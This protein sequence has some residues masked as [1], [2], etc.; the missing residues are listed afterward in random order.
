MTNKNLNDDVKDKNQQNTAK[1]YIA[2]KKN[3]ADVETNKSNILTDRNSSKIQTVK[4]T[5]VSCRNSIKSQAVKSMVIVREETAIKKNAPEK[6]SQKNHVAKENI[7]DKSETE[8]VGTEITFNRCENAD[9]VKE[10][11]F[12]KFETQ[13][14]YNEFQKEAIKMFKNKADQV[15]IEDFKRLKAKYTHEELNETEIEKFKIIKEKNVEI[16]RL[17]AEYINKVKNQLKTSE[18]SGKI[19]RKLVEVKNSM[20]LCKSNVENGKNSVE[21]QVVKNTIVAEK[22]LPQEKAVKKT[23]SEENSW[24]EWVEKEEKIAC[25]IL[26]IDTS[27]IQYRCYLQN[28]KYED[29]TEKEKADY[30]EY[31]RMKAKYSRPA[32][33]KQEQQIGRM[34]QQD[35]EIKQLKYEHSRK[36]R[37]IVETLKDEEKLKEHLMDESFDEDERELVYKECMRLSKI[38]EEELRNTS[39]VLEA[40]C[41]DTSSDEEGEEG[42]QQSGA[43]SKI[44]CERKNKSL[45]KE[46]D[47]RSDGG[48]SKNKCSNKD[49]S[50]EAESNLVRTIRDGSYFE[51]KRNI[52]E[53]RN[54]NYKAA[55]K[56]VDDQMAQMSGSLREFE[57]HS[58]EDPNMRI[59]FKDDFS[60][61]TKT[62]SRL[63]MTPINEAFSGK[64]NFDTGCFSCMKKLTDDHFS[65]VNSKI[66][67]LQKKIKCYNVVKGMKLDKQKADLLKS[68]L[69]EYLHGTQDKGRDVAG[70]SSGL[71]GNVYTDLLKSV[72]K[73]YCEGVKKS[74]QG[75]RRSVVAESDLNDKET[76]QVSSETKDDLVVRLSGQIDDILSCQLAQQS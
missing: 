62:F 56:Y 60:D 75:K 30:D 12:D 5:V 17:R 74:D 49:N 47:V 45:N 63:S 9:V 22:N 42:S 66:D 27:S 52:R 70:R 39:I 18:S 21:S 20:L 68:M 1:N 44:K 13:N 72:V 4:N 41:S 53:E 32:K 58:K 76:D 26:G 65:N 55:V 7:S 67:T 73:D 40:A 25:E 37:A 3:L 36:V 61:L 59:V 64:T 15:T 51:N 43:V 11:L 46:S 23:A 29:L 48:Q 10:N 19:G 14:K 71:S 33:T 57:N 8:V 31:M 24:K 28:F 6:N 50:E 34:K 35:E 38:S 69:K 54:K 16:K 2:T